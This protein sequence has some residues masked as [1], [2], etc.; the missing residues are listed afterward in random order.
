MSSK[1]RTRNAR[2]RATGPRNPAEADA[3]IKVA[4]GEA[5]DYVCK[6]VDWDLARDPD[7]VL[8]IGAIV[9]AFGSQL[10]P[11]QLQ[12]HTQV[13]LIVKAIARTLPDEDLISLLAHLV[14]QQTGV[15]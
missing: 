9:N 7:A 15:C 1:S 12:M 6:V 2:K 10:T 4:Q 5:F 14:A 13:A 11:Y 3:M 8:L